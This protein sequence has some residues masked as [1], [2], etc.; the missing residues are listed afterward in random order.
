MPTSMPITVFDV[1]GRIM[2]GPSSSHTAGAARIGKIGRTLLGCTPQEA[3]IE[4]H[5]SFSETGRGHGTDKALLAGLLGMDPSDGRI[6]DSYRL[7][8]ET[9]MQ[10]QFVDV[11][12][13]EDVHPN[14]ARLTLKAGDIRVVMAASSIGGGLVRVIEIQG[15]MVDFSGELDTLLIIAADSPGTIN[16]VTSWLR[17]L[18]IN[19]AFF[20]VTRQKRGGEAIMALETDQP[21]PEAVITLISSLPW[22]KWCR[23]LPAAN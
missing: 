10:F 19:V 9:G 15:Y 5:G 20:R 8:Q 14:T 12:L 3:L 17:E 1:I 13:G 18:N 4:L 22:V 23:Q 7:A 21:I 2:V 11:D 16:A 6:R